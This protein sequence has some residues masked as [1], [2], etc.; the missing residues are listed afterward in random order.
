MGEGTGISAC[1]QIS[2]LSMQKCTTDEQGPAGISACQRVGTLEIY[3]NKTKVGEG[4]GMWA[5]QHVNS[6]EVYTCIW[7]N[8]LNLYHNILLI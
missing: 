7:S 3:K 4:A 5:C 8:N 1:R 2:T 6:L